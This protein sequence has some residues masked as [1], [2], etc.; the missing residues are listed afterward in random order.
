VPRLIDRV[1]LSVR[2]TAA[3]RAPTGF[4]RMERPDGG[5]GGVPRSDR[6]PRGG[7]PWLSM[8]V[9]ATTASGTLDP[10]AR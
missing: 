5:V 2:T 8:I 3:R 10:G 7:S 9:V 6:D 4:R 1:C